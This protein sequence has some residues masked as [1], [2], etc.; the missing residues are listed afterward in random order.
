MNILPIE[1]VV[2]GSTLGTG[3]GYMLMPAAPSSSQ[4]DAAAAQAE[5]KQAVQAEQKPNEAQVDT[6]SFEYVKLN[7]QFVVPVVADGHVVSL[8]VVSL[9]LEVDA[10]AT[11]DVYA[12]EPKLVDGFLRALFDHANVGGFEG[13]F[14]EAGKTELLR[15]ALHFEAKA[16]LGAS[17]HTVL[18]TNLARQDV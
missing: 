13:N 5:P 14:T 11:E 8:V 4:D 16:V 10:A 15:K 3:A 9:S 1:M 17:V 2:L 18:I 12:R 7:N 6:S